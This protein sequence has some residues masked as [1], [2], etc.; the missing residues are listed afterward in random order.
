M[1][2][3]HVASNWAKKYSKKLYVLSFDHNLR[4]DSFQDIELVKFTTKSLNLEHKYFIWKEK[5]SSAILEKARIA[6]YKTFSKYC[7][8]KDIE[9]LL[10]AHTAD[11][12]AETM[13]IRILNK[14]NLDG[15]C[16]MLKQ[17]KLFD[18]FLV[19][20]LLHL[21]KY[22][23]Y[24]FAQAYSIKYNEDP[25]NS[26][27]KF[28]RSRVR[29]YLNSNNKLTEG[30]I[31]ASLLYC[32]LR[33]IKSEIIK[34]KFKDYFDYKIEGYV[35]IKK[36][37]L[38]S[39]PKFLILSFFKNCLMQIGN[40]KYPPSTKK[41]I[42]L[43]SK[44]NMHII[45]NFSLCGCIISFRKE[46]ILIIREYNKIKNLDMK[47]KNKNT[48]LWDNRFILSNLPKNKIYNI[49]PL[50]NIMDK[51]YTKIILKKY[52]KNNCKTPFFVKKAL[53]VIKTLEGW[54]LIPHFN[55]YGSTDY[56]IK[57]DINGLYNKNDNNNF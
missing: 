36:E 47:L 2:L 25:S 33:K 15:L 19:R 34:N 35:V 40:R 51:S 42:E 18:I 49:F 41:L 56:K 43:F 24:K 48:L 23:I 27:N 30:F 7:R 37:L 4:K 50:G 32:K 53:P 9:V 26:N 45:T 3:L 29:K 5:P 21:R 17:K 16:P 57:I 28:L 46:E 31:K 55:I 10:V 22:E 1:S 12:I 8:S 13:A 38:L 39:F 6:R 11:D 20:P 14:S 44:S 54:I 52:K